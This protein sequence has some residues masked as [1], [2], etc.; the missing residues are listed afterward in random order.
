M[1]TL[2]PSILAADMLRLENEIKKIEYSG[3][4]Y[5][6]IDVMDGVFVPNISFGACVYKCIRE[7][8]NLFFDVHLMITDPERYI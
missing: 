4:K 6:H 5:V 3:S 2:S 1:K 7:K 8:S